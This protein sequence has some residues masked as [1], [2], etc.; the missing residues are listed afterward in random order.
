MTKEEGITLTNELVGKIYEG[1]EIIK[2]L[3]G[4]SD[5]TKQMNTFASQQSH[6][7]ALNDLLKITGS[8]GADTEV[9]IIGAAKAMA[10]VTKGGVD[11]AQH[12]D[13]QEVIDSLLSRCVRQL[14]LK[15]GFRFF[16]KVFQSKVS[17][18]SFLCCIMAALR[19]TDSLH[20]DSDL[21][22]FLYKV[23]VTVTSNN[24]QA[25][26]KQATMN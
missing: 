3:P 6:S 11:L 18:T 8:S 9:D 15:A 24:K 19:F 21:Q 7:M 1:L 12:V 23:T 10:A 22:Y 17:L 2:D 13:F 26:S 4:V 14:F 20:S 5:F 16:S 25:A